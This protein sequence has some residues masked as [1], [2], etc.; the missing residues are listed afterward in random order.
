M[1]VEDKSD[2]PDDAEVVRMSFASAFELGFRQLLGI[3]DQIGRSQSSGGISKKL[4]VLLRG[5]AVLSVAREK[6]PITDF[7]NVE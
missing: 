4:L 2:F 6:I 3:V 5:P 1:G 7:F